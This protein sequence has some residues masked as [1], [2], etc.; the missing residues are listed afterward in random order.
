MFFSARA[1]F[2]RLQQGVSVHADV[3]YVT[4]KWNKQNVNFWQASEEEEEFCV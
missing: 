2:V 3:L 4:L 1:L